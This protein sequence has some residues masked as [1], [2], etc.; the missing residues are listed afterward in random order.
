MSQGSEGILTPYEFMYI[1]C[2]ADDTK[3]I[4]FGALVLTSRSPLLEQK[5]AFY[6]TTRLSDVIE[7]GEVSLS[8]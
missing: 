8:R 3:P 6:A 1:I 5:S 2:Q 4:I 7:R